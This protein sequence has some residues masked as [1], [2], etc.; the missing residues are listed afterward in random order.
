M[1]T[2]SP[3]IESVE[4]L[5]RVPADKLNALEAGGRLPWL[6]MSNNSNS[7]FRSLCQTGVWLGVS[8]SLVIYPPLEAESASKHSLSQRSD[9]VLITLDTTRADALGSYGATVPTPV[10]DRLAQQGIRFDRAISPSP[11]TLPA[12]VSLMTGLAPPSH[13]IHDNG[14]NS[15]EPS[16]PTLA[17]VLTTHGYKTAAVVGSLVL[18]RRFGLDSGFQTYDDVMAAEAVGEYGY[19]ERTAEKVTEAALHWLRQQNGEGMTTDKKSAS[20]P[21]FLWVHYY[22]PHAP[23]AAPGDRAIDVREQYSAEIRFVDQQI[24]RLL[25]GLPDR[26]RIVAVVGDHGEALGQHG[27]RTHGLLLHEPTLRVPLILHGAGIEPNSVVADTVASRRLA[28]TLLQLALGHPELPGPPLPGFQDASDASEVSVATETRA[29]YSET[30]LPYTAYGWSVLEALTEE[31][32]RWV[33]GPRGELFDL[34]ADPTEKDNLVDTRRREAKRLQQTLNRLHE[35][36]DPPKTTHSVENAEVSQALRSL[37]YLSGASG[38]GVGHPDPSRIDPKEGLSLLSQMEEAKQLSSQG[39]PRKALVILKS[40]VEKNPENVPLLGHLARNQLAVARLEGDSPQIGLETYKQALSLNPRLEFLHLGLAQAFKEL[41]RLDSAAEAYRAALAIDSRNAE[42]WLSVA[43]IAH[44]QGSTTGERQAL[45]SALD[46]GTQSAAILIRLAQLE[47]ADS[48][49]EST[50][51][52][53]QHLR[54]A[55]KITPEWPMAWLMLGRWELDFGSPPAARKALE[56]V[57][58]RA[59]RSREAIQARSWL[60]GG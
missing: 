31:Q 1:E 8:L 4:P 19:P 23:Y 32:F 27:E 12:H 59:P 41:G 51:L 42:A 45:E 15:L 57:L 2:T 14:L 29:V 33:V 20:G 39:H 21:L 58:Q 37:G 50:T 49:P 38:R 46:R 52:A 34:V 22:D 47:M 36:M 18:N 35:S 40:L 25:S 55:T 56:Q 26:S 11:L 43:E 9:I 60:S 3:F 17:S 54:L 5:P 28:A 48:L 10:L 44:R 24:G 16:I 53:G 7:P 13:G 30:H 6:H